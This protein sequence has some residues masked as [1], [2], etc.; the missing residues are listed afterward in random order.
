MAGIV[1][2]SDRTRRRAELLSAGY[3]PTSTDDTVFGARFVFCWAHH[4]PHP[5]G[6]CAVELAD[7]TPLD[8]VRLLAA[9]DEA[10]DRGFW[11]YGD[12]RPCSDCGTTLRLQRSTWRAVDGP[13]TCP[14]KTAQ[15]IYPLTHTPDIGC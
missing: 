10:R 6:A 7:K 1:T 14:E 2:V 4:H 5:A 11:V 9:T 8:A 12:P 13:D 3:D 15:N